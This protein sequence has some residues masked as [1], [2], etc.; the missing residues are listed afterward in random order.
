VT[1]PTSAEQSEA[2]LRAGV[3]ALL[4][5]LL[6]A[7]PAPA[8][9]AQLQTIQDSAASSQDD[10]AIAWT[11]LKQAAALAQ[12]DRL[13]E[14]FHDLFIGLGR[15]E[16]APYG[17]WYLTGFLM[18]KPL[19]ALRRDLARLGYARGDDVHEPEDHI[20]ALCEI[21]ALLVQDPAISLAQQRRFFETHLGGWIERFFQ[22]LE[23]ADSARFYR[24]VGRLGQTFIALERRYL[25][26]LA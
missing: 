15:G 20:A 24:A 22:D 14:E 9:L 16:L 11:A 12:P 10:V 5:N 26:M 19:G 8:L 3:Y 6:A 17:S 25:T 7:P 18:E 4:A 2:Q 23:Q 13:R 1:A 21:M